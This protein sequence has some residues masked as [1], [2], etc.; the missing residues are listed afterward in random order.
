MNDSGVPSSQNSCCLDGIARHH[1][2]GPDLALHGF[3]GKAHLDLGE[4]HLGLMALRRLKA[5]L[6]GWRRSWSDLAQ[7]A[8]QN[9]LATLIAESPI[10]RCNREPVS[11]GQACRRS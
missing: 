11:S 3:S 7:V 1:G 5:H 2:K 4:V 8:V 10:S 6:K 9:G